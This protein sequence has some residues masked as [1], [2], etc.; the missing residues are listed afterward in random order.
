MAQYGQQQQYGQQYE[1]P[2]AVPDQPYEYMDEASGQVMV[3]DPRNGMS[4]TTE[5][6]QQMQQQQQQP[7]QQQYQQQQYAQ[8]PQ[9]TQYPS[10]QQP[11]QQWGEPA[12]NQFPQ[13]SQQQPQQQQQ[14]PKPQARIDPKS[15]PRPLYNYSETVKF[16]TRAGTAPPGANTNYVAIDEGNASPRFMRLT[17][18]HIPSTPELSDMSRIAIG[19]IIQPFANLGREEEP[20]PVVDF[21][22]AGPLRCSRCKA[23]V[24]P[25]FKFVE[26]GRTFVCNL[27]DQKN[28]GILHFWVKFFSLIALS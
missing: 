5:Y 13:Q 4:Y 28:E 22:P 10:F 2:A 23:Y 3:Y 18:N 17:C 7:Q 26:G 15:I 9:Q 16:F 14:T 25:F 1:Q 11:Q 12:Q 20:V 8:T 27:C 21:G 6:Y 19:A 24:N